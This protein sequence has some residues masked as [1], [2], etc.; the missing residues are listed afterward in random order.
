MAADAA[1]PAERTP[2]PERTAWARN[3]GAPVRDFLSTETGGAAMLVVAAAAALIWANLP[4]SS[5]E[6]FWHMT[7]SIRLGAHLLS[8]DLRS[9]VNEGLMTLFFLVVGL[10]AKRELALGELRERRRIAIPVLAAAGGIVAAVGVYLA[11]NA[12]GPGAK[13]WGIAMSTD[14]ALALGALALVGPRGGARLRVFLLTLVVIDDLAGLAVIAFAYSREI[15]L[16]ALSVALGLFIVLIALRYLRAGRGPASVLVAI[17]IWLAMFESGID[18]VIA[19]LAIGLIT[20]AYPPSRGD[21]ER[22][23]ELTR[24]FREQPTPELA[25]SAQ[26]GLREA[27]SPNEQLQHRL[28]PWSGFLVVPLFALANMGLRLNG[29]LLSVAAGSAVSIGILLA[30]LV[31]KPLGILAA[32]WLGSRRGLGRGRLTVTWPG[33]AGTGAVAGVG[34]TVSLLIASRA[35][36]GVGGA[37]GVG[38]AGGAGGASGASLLAQAQLGLLAA[39]LLSPLLALTIFRAAARLP[40]H[41]RVRQMQ[42]T[43]EQLVDLADDVDPERDHVRGAHAAPVTLVEYADFECPYC[44]RAETAIRDLLATEGDELRYVFRH[45]PLS[46]VH[47]FAQLAA[48]AAEAAGA[49]GRFWEM[50]DLLFEHQGDLRPKDV[51]GYAEQL[52]LDLD[53]FDNELHSRAYKP[54]VS[55][56]VTSADAS[57]V[58]GTPSFF[59][60]GRRHH[61][62]YDLKTLTHAVKAAARLA[63]RPGL[64]RV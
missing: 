56:D 10:E 24:A 17:G 53:R 58:S 31:G 61:G 30:Y 64:Q 46:D 21:L 37:G 6:S 1:A 55:E 59:V 36:R 33:L 26:R 49:Q 4:A 27:I 2:R 14:T 32:S 43:A 39:V 9:W 29:H 50:H 23:I 15:S 40:A 57:G 12:G 62:A 18:P 60:N 22:A 19:G 48:E 42:R 38:A 63:G 11:L 54:R 45:L 41:V 16:V 44:G 25:R 7:L 35:F 8:A 5:Y 20:S 3:L 34:F 52:S 28:H 51:R 47:P 13:G